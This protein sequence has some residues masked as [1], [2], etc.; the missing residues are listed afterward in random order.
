MNTI[1]KREGILGVP[2][3]LS[4]PWWSTKAVMTVSS[5]KR[6]LV[7]QGGEQRFFHHQCLTI[8][9]Y[10]TWMVSYLIADDAVDQGSRV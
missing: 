6:R 5:I 10:R 4:N 1:Q 3:T 2:D 9:E 7:G 8:A